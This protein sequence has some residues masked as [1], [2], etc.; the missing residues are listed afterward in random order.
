[1]RTN[2][3]TSDDAPSAPAAAFSENRFA[4]VARM[5]LLLTLLFP[6]CLNLWLFRVLLTIASI[7]GLAK[8]QIARRP[9]FWLVLGLTNFG[10]QNV[11]NWAYTDN[12]V[13]LYSYWYLAISCALFSETPMRVLAAN[14]RA[15][16]GLVFLFA[17]LQKL[18]SA[19][20]VSTDAVTFFLVHDRRFFRLGQLAGLHSNQVASLHRSMSELLPSIPLPLSPRL[21]AMAEFITWWTVFLEGAIALAFLC[22]RASR[23]GRICDLALLVFVATVGPIAPVMGF[24]WVLLIMGYCQC[25]D[26]K[27]ITLVVYQALFVLAICFSFTRVNALITKL[28]ALLAPA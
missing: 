11:Y 9:E 24:G 14:A 8:P 23:V 7:A 3:T 6:G 4:T 5:T 10:L 12:H 25:S 27:R 15:M 26:F 18:L 22:R 20:F 19:E 28:S 16:V 2:Q 13:C 21:A 1:M 17:T